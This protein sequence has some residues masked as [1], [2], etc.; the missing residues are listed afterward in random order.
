[1]KE[2]KQK[3]QA[4]IEEHQSKEGGI[5]DKFSYII[6]AGF[7]DEENSEKGHLFSALYGSHKKNVE[8]VFAA[9]KGDNGLKKVFLD[10]F[11]CDIL[12]GPLGKVKEALAKEFD[13]KEKECKCDSEGCRCDNAEKPDCTCIEGC[14]PGPCKE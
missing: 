10:A 5:S 3:L 8:T 7:D 4:L 2:F 6:I 1:M 9:I 12:S 13:P 11:M 14:G